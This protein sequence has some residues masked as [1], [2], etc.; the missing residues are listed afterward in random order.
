ME[1]LNVGHFWKPEE[2]A[3]YVKMATDRF[4]GALRIVS[5]LL[6]VR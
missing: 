6:L 4:Q 2:D 5:L 1:P 3:E